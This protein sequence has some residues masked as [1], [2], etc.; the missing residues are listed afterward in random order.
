MLAATFVYTILFSHFRHIIHPQ[1][2]PHNP[3]LAVNSAHRKNTSVL[4]S[5]VFIQESILCDE[6]PVP[7]AMFIAANIKITAV[8]FRKPYFRG[9]FRVKFD[10]KYPVTSNICHKSNV[11]LLAHF[12]LQRDIKIIFNFFYTEFML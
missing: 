9:L 12:M 4:I 5:D 2:L 7:Q 6:T 11:M 10:Q 8:H 3:C 1:N